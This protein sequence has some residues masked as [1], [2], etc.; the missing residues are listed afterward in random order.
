M[1]SQ[2]VR[3]LM[4]KR[5]LL[6]ATPDATVLNACEGMPKKNTGAVLGVQDGS[7]VG[8][9][10]ERDAVF[11]VIAQGRDPAL[12]RL[13]EVMTPSPKTI[14]PDKSFGYAMMLMHKN[15]FRHLPVIENGKPVGIVSARNALD[16]DLEEFVSETRRRQRILEEK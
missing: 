16:P 2:P 10:T 15:G 1:F 7:L 6:S 4:E 12:T 9:F 3:G 5:K 14:D 13:V 8:I 11:R